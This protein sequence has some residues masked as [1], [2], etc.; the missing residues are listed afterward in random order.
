MEPCGSIRVVVVVNDQAVGRFFTVKRA[1]QN[2]ADK[3]R[4]D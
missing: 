2:A 3:W 4:S 1:G